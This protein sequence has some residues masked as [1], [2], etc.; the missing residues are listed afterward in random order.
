MLG[1]HGQAHHYS[2]YLALLGAQLYK[3]NSD[4]QVRHGRRQR[5]LSCGRDGPAWGNGHLGPQHLTDI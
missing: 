1:I 5:C 3:L 2:H 4:V